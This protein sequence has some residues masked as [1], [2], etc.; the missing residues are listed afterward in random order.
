MIKQI[1]Y[2]S[3][4]MPELENGGLPTGS[5]KIIDIRVS[6]VNAKMTTLKTFC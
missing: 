2:G 3:F 4:E 5:T 1:Y 6:N